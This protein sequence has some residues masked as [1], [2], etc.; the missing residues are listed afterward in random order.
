[1]RVSSQSLREY[2]SVLNHQLVGHEL[3]LDRYEEGSYSHSFVSGKIRA[4][5]EA[6]TQFDAI[7]PD[8]DGDVWQLR[9]YEA[10][11]GLSI[12]SLQRSGN[13][14]EGTCS[15]FDQELKRKERIVD[16]F[17]YLGIPTEIAREEHREADRR[18]KMMCA[19]RDFVGSWA[20]GIEES[21]KLLYLIF[22][23]VFELVA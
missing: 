8:L 20:H 23:D 19:N 16:D 3:S 15:S 22:P 14:Y 11:L 12:Q 18:Y 5:E 6:L 4:W 17:V 7:F 21:L 2:R 10:I 13:M 1:M 9:R